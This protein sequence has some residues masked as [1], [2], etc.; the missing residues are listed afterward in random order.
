MGGTQSGTPEQGRE[1]ALA[2]TWRIHIETGPRKVAEAIADTAQIHC[3]RGLT[4]ACRWSITVAYV[5]V[6]RLLRGASNVLI[7]VQL[8]M[9]GTNE[10]RGS[11][12]GW[13]HS[14]KH[15]WTLLQG[16][17]ATCETKRLRALESDQTS[18]SL[19]AQT[20]PRKASKP[21]QP[22]AWFPQS[23]RRQQM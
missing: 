6:G 5:G 4:P 9:F 1:L 22:R 11:A 8:D 23:K 19:I 2:Y 17:H 3:G 18:Q 13:C 21:E 12:A 20:L 7:E 16:V 15:S 14:T 10:S